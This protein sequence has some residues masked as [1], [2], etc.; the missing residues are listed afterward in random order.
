M[1]ALFSSIHSMKEHINSIPSLSDVKCVDVLVGCAD[2]G[3][4]TLEVFFADGKELII[5]ELEYD[6]FDLEE[7]SEEELTT[8]II[9]DIIYAVSLEQLNFKTLN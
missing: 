1:K 6:Q 8:Q 2:G 5:V 4:N 9:E 7:M 3:L